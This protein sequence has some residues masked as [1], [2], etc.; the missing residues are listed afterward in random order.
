MSIRI[1]RFHRSWHVPAELYKVDDNTIRPE[2]MDLYMTFLRHKVWLQIERTGDLSEED[3]DRISSLLE[4][5]IVNSLENKCTG[6]WT[7]DL[8]D[9]DKNRADD[10]LSLFIMFEKEEDLTE[11]LKTDAIMFRLEV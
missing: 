11:F 8:D 2:F 9:N 4:Q 6:F 5:R 3:E 10:T 1:K 7:A